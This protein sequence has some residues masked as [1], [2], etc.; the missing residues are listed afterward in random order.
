MKT[1][2][3]A[4]ALLLAPAAHAVEIVHAGPELP[5]TGAIAIPVLTGGVLNGPA[6]AADQAANG[7]IARA[8]K[9]ADFKGEKDKT[10]T[11]FA[12]G[13]YDRVLLVGV[14]AGL[15]TQT[16]LED[17]GGRLAPALKAGPIAAAVP[18]APGIPADA[19]HA[20]FGAELG[21]YDFGK[22]GAK[23]PAETRRLTLHS[24]DAAGATKT[25]ASD[26]AYAAEGVA[27]ARDMI[28]TPSNIKTPQYMVEAAQ[29][30][31]A[32]VKGV[33]IEV[34]GVPEMQK[35][36][37]GALLGVGQGSTRPPR[38]LI[39]RY[40]GAGAAAPIAFVGKG[41]TFDSGGISIKPADGMWRMRYDMSGAAASLGAVLAIAQRGAKVN[42]IAV[43]ALAENMPDGGAIRPGDVLTTM[44]GKTTEVLNTDAEGRLVL[45][46][47]VAY[48][49]RQDK[50]RAV[51][52]IATL[53]GAVRTALGDD[54]AGLF[55][56][57]PALGASLAKAAEVSGEGVWPLPIHESIKDDLKSDVADIKNVVEASGTPGASIGA[58]FIQA[59]IEPNQAWAHLDIAGMAWATTATAT[60]PKGAVGFGVRLFDAYARSVEGQ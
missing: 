16:D 57:D 36:G 18:D 42:A 30:A 54:Y 45:A 43:A 56:N 40:A 8:I 25:F 22:W 14:G 12:I 15:K 60:V 21:A 32:G 13:P 28:S 19:A 10:A 55:T 34:L 37:M 50:P 6:A 59:W 46:D 38:L 29:K 53:T 35:L 44:T 9:A 20:A 24:A 26:K 47:A 51:I 48:V 11:L 23:K 2:L 52:T 58:G 17:F 31:F 49:Q 33:S 27:F 4:A 3:F 41:I 7:A 1:H 39:V 5:K